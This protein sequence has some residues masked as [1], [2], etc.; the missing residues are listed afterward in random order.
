MLFFFRISSSFLLVFFSRI[1]SKYLFELSEYIQKCISGNTSGKISEYE[2]P[3]PR[4]IVPIGKDHRSQSF[5]GNQRLTAPTGSGTCFFFF[6]FLFFF[7]S[8]SSSFH[9]LVHDY[10]WGLHWDLQMFCVW[11]L[12]KRSP[13]RQEMGA[14]IL[15]NC[16]SSCG[17][18]WIRR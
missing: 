8:S 3:K 9:P 18:V 11:N 17:E 2:T 10:V 14:A 4:K 7:F 16:I 12:G 6:S 15:G 13:C 1:W 5:H